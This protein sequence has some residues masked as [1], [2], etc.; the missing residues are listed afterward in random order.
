M[1]TA[2]ATPQTG[3]LQK[4]EAHPRADTCHRSAVQWSIDEVIISNIYYG[5]IIPTNFFVLL[6]ACPLRLGIA[7]VHVT[8]EER[9]EEEREELTYR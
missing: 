9:K 5:T 8:P 3:G 2:P 4:E 7:V 1:A 6:R